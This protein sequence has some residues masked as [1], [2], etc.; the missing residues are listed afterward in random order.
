VLRTEVSLPV[1]VD[2]L[3]E[4]PFPPGS[5]E[6]CLDNESKRGKKNPVAVC[7]DVSWDRSVAWVAFAGLRK[8]GL[9]HVEVVARRAGTD[10]VIPWLLERVKP[11]K[12]RTVTFQ[13]NGA[14]VSSA[15][16]GGEAGGP[17]L[18]V[19]WQGADLGRWTGLFYDRVRAGQ[20]R[21]L[22]QPALDTAAAS[23]STKPAGDAWV[24]DRKHSPVDIAPLVAVTGALGALLNDEP[25]FESAYSDSDYELLIL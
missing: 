4:G 22:A 15:P 3:I 19:D 14:P 9:V 20:V 24:W 17:A 10:W 16:R 12:I 1:V 7:V 5:W 25:E 11:M 8:D 18:P 23:A 2:G 21:H 6:A 13:T